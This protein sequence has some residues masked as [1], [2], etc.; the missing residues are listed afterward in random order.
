MREL[1]WPHN[2]DHQ[3]GVGLS[4]DEMPSISKVHPLFLVHP[5]QNDPNGSLPSNL[6][7]TA[8]GYPL[9]TAPGTTTHLGQGPHSHPGHPVSSLSFIPILNQVSTILC[10]KWFLV[11]VVLNQE[12]FYP[13]E[14]H[15]AKSEDI[16]GYH[17]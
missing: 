16:L 3:P 14:I 15:T 11:L 12:H 10:P 2:G 7:L 6:F 8:P 5:N 13:Q 4:L 17:W 9:L 1:L